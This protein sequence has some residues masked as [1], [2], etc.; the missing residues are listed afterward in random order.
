MV[1]DKILIILPFVVFVVLLFGIAVFML[2]DVS[3]KLIFQARIAKIRHRLGMSFLI[4]AKRLLQPEMPRAQID[5]EV[6]DIGRN[7]QR[8]NSSAIGARN[9]GFH[10]D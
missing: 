8:S 2:K 10:Y 9:R 7:A 3:L 6:L 1:S 4:C 5:Y